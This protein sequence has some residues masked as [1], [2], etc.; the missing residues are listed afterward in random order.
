MGTQNSQRWSCTSSARRRPSPARSSSSRPRARRCSSTAGCSRATRTRRSATASR[1]PTTPRTS[2][3]WSSRTRTSIT[4]ASSRSLSR[5]ACAA[6][7]FATAGTVELAD[8]RAPRLGEAAGRRPRSATRGSSADPERAA[9]VDRAAGARPRATR[10][11]K[12]RRSRREAAAE[13]RDPEPVLRSQPPEIETEHR[14]P[15]LHR[16][17]RAGRA[18]ASSGRR[19]R[20][21]SVEV[22]PG[23]RATFL[24][25]GHIL[26]SAIIRF[27]RATATGAVDRVL[28]R[29][30]TPRHA[31]HPRP[32]ARQ[33]R[34]LRGRRVDVRRARAR[35]A[36]GGGPAPRRGRAP[37]RRERRASCSCRRSRSAGRRRSCGSWTACSTRGRSRTSRSTSTRRWPRRPAPSTAATRSTSTRRC[38][39]SSRSATTR[40]TIPARSSRTTSRSRARSRPRRG[41][42]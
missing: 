9:R 27:G 13:E 11:T 5:R 38:A 40:S 12:R 34:G 28:G 29:P 24:D 21:A 15:A 16:G 30:R 35:A 39:R 14:R 17:R 23:V 18:R 42:T 36:G 20:A 8:A 19:L 37:R 31:D 7:I 32:H 4:A 25:A 2:T 26:G 10:A 22:A 6:P 33:R 3:R 1:S 41:R